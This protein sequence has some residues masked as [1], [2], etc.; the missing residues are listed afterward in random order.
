MDLMNTI[1]RLK[2]LKL[3]VFGHIHGSAGVEVINRTTFVNASIMNEEYE[4]TN[5]PIV[6]EI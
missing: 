3:H 5:K 6:I 1:P 2:N 4:C